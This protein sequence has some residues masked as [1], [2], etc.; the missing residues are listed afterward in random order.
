LY[1]EIVQFIS[2]FFAHMHYQSANPGRKKK[3]LERKICG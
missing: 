2:L 1:M 3:F